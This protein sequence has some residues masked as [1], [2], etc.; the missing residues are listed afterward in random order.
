MLELRNVTKTYKDGCTGISN[1]NLVFPNT[2]FI[3]I[4]GKSGSGK[5]T[6]LN[7]IA[8]V[9]TPSEGEIFYNNTNIKKIPKYTLNKVS[10]V[11]QDYNLFMDLDV[12]SNI[13]FFNKDDLVIKSLGISDLT[14]KKIGEISGG[15]ARRVAIARALNKK[16]KILICDEPT[17]SLDKDNT[18]LIINM[19]KEISKKILVIIVSHENEM[20]EPYVDE[21]IE[22]NCSKVVAESVINKTKSSKFI[23][24]KENRS[25]ADNLYAS[26]LKYTVGR[27]KKN[28]VLVFLNLLLFF[29][30]LTIFV[31]SFFVS[32]IDYDNIEVTS[33]INNNKNRISILTDYNSIDITNLNNEFNSLQYAYEYAN[34]SGL[35]DLS[36][37]DYN[38]N[39][40][41]KGFQDT[42]KIVP[43]NSTTFTKDDEIYGNLPSNKDEVL[44]TEYLFECIKDLGIDV[45]GEKIY[46]IDMNDII[47]K[48][49]LLG[50]SYVKVSGILRQ[51]LDKYKFLKKQTSIDGRYSEI[52]STVFENDIINYNYIYVTF[53][54]FS[55][56]NMSDVSI[57]NIFV[58]SDSAD[59]LMKIKKFFGN[60]PYYTISA[61]SNIIDEFYNMVALVRNGFN[62]LL[63]ISS[64]ILIIFLLYYLNNLISNKIGEIIN[65]FYL[66]L[67]SIF[68]VSSYILELL[69][70]L[71]PVFIWLGI[72]VFFSNNVFSDVLKN[73]FITEISFTLY[74]DR[75]FYQL[76]VY[77]FSI[78]FISFVFLY[79]VIK[80]KYKELYES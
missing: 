66:G 46:P 33:L 71:I 53:D 15:E 51:D 44:I 69:L 58:N 1:V 5:T 13:N 64:I 67:N 49:I 76:F 41:Y 48:K 57:A 79:R 8:G 80:K 77:I 56:Y 21:V 3:L 26:M 75:V 63:I 10:Y 45:Y 28:F 61:Y 43:I 73:Y 59:D 68:I 34:S 2:G 65:M 11:Y 31:I 50:D 24:C 55:R 14:K 6:L 9:L 32:N 62:F 4:K 39:I 54:Y 16:T 20:I 36:D 42:S 74:N 38:D 25:V 27:M 60:Y 30:T 7:L 78:F 37:S 17:E 29:F 23:D 52:I 18:K 35:L 70:T 72:M 12:K 19:L 22:I 40:F 47:N